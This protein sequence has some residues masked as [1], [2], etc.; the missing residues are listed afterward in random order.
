MQVNEVVAYELKSLPLMRHLV[1][2]AD[3]NP[4]ALQNLPV[5]RIFIYDVSVL[6][7]GFAYLDYRISFDELIEFLSY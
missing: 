7:D 3:E 2:L 4:S 1:S 5:G 6:Y